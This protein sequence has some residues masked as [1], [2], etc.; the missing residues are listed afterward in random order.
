VSTQVGRRADTPDRQG[1]R[2]GARI[3]PHVHE[4]LS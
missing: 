1:T 3:Q 4:P 2:R